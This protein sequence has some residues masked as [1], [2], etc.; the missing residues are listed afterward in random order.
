[1]LVVPIELIK[2]EDLRND[3]K[4][5]PE[6]DFGICAYVDCLKNACFGVHLIINKKEYIMYMCKE[7]MH[8]ICKDFNMH[9]GS[10]IS[11]KVYQQK[12]GV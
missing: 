10:L 5:D 7:H 11:N 9:I 6:L 3:I 2:I 8:E 4:E 12:L 1:M